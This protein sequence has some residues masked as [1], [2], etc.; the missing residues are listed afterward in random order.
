MQKIMDTRL[1][2]LTWAVVDEAPGQPRQRPCATQQIDTFVRRIEDRAALS[3]QERKEVKQYL[4][5]RKHLIQELY[6]EQ[7][8]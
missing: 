1:L 4:R 5:D 7:I 2:R 6:Q 3:S 8:I